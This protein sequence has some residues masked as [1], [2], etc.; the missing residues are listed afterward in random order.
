MVKINGSQDERRMQMRNRVGKWFSRLKLYSALMLTFNGIFLLAVMIIVLTTVVVT[1]NI[2]TNNYAQYAG[3]MLDG[4]ATNIEYIANDIKTMSWYVISDSDIQEI[5]LMEESEEGYNEALKLAKAEIRR[6]IIERSY[7][8]S[9]SIYNFDGEGFSVGSNPSSVGGFDE[10]QK[11]EW[12]AEML[13]KKGMY[14]WGMAEFPAYM[15]TQYRTIFAR[16]INRTDSLDGLGF[17]VFTLDNQ[18]LEEMIENISAPS[19]GNFYVLGEDGQVIFGR[20]E[21]EAV[22]VSQTELIEKLYLQKEGLYG[23]KLKNYRMGNWYLNTTYVSNLGWELICIGDGLTVLNGQWV[24]LIVIFLVTILV[25]IIA[26][27]VYSRLSHMITREVGN[28]HEIMERAEEQNF[29]EEI[30][31]RRIYEF[32]QLGEAYN[33]LIRRINVLVNEVMQEKLNVKQAQFESLQAQ[34]NPHF[35]YN[36]LNCIEWEALANDQ[37]GVAEMI[38]CL[39]RMFRFSLQS[40]EKSIPLEKEIENVRDYLTLQKKRFADSLIYLIDV[41][42]EVRKCRV[43]KFFLQ[44]LVE[45]SIL[46]G[47]QKRREGGYVGISA[48]LEE[49]MLVIRVWDDGVGIDEEKIQLLL[50]GK[51]YEEQQK[52][53][54][55]G[56]YNVNERLVMNYGEESRLQFENRTVGGTKVTIRISMEKLR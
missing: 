51:T 11:Q 41:Q 3:Q 44:P 33:R 35:L 21:Q 24:N 15:D 26:S 56:I 52:R 22:C 4:L 1:G 2:T 17:L 48:G 6:L 20:R 29:K 10:F 18:Y 37:V 36:T 45:N 28:L 38:Q 54:R 8:E 12:Y 49:N 16:V 31:I 42:E 40:G 5:L 46:H 14:V 19:I 27:Y 47:I 43:I 30:K 55:H 13:E 9:L 34:I 32:I 53:H 7:V 39:S 25:I 23:G 50:E